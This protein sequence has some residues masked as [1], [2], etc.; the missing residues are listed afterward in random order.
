MLHL[1][2]AAAIAAAVEG[3]EAVS[4]GGGFIDAE[5][6]VGLAFIAL[7]GIFAYYGVHRKIVAA[8]DARAARI[9]AQ[10]DEARTLKEEAHHLLAQHQRK[11]R[12][13]ARDA[14]AIIEHAREEAAIIAKDVRAQIDVLIERRTRLAQQRIAQAE[15]AAVKDVRAAA[16]EVASA[17][18]ERVIVQHLQTEKQKALADAAIA[19]LDRSIH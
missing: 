1:L 10:L 3:G 8:L 14:E 19:E 2:I 18:A 12:E 13:A 11:Q 4:H 7:L 5:F 6:W 16:V 15:A 17:A 9:R